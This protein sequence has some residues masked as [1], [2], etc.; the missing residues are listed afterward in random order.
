MAF[1][2]GCETELPSPDA[3]VCT[4]CGRRVKEQLRLIVHDDKLRQ[5]VFGGI[6]CLYS[7]V[8]LVGL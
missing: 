4:N 5:G 8:S 6:C 1:C 3:D 7:L 2:S